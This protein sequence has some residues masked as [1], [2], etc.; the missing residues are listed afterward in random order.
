MTFQHSSYLP[1]LDGWRCVAVIAVICN[2]VLLR[3]GHKLDPLGLGT[4]GVDLF[5]AISGLLITYRMLEEHGRTGE[6]GLRSFYI[7]RAFRILP[8]ALLFLVVVGVLSVAG[9][10]PVS[11]MEIVSSL[12]FFRNYYADATPLTWYTVHYWSLSVEEH[13]YL[14]WPAL[15]IWLGIARTRKWTPWLALAIAA[16]R[17]LDSHF[18]FISSPKLLYLLC[19]T[20]YRLDALLWGC[21][22]ALLLNEPEWRDRLRRIPPWVPFVALPIC[23]WLCVYRP[24][25][26]MVV[27]AL[28]FP[29]VVVATLLHPA[30]VLSSTL[31]VAPLRF[32][33]KISYGIYLWQQLFFIRTQPNVFGPFQRFP[34]NVISVIVLA[35][36]SYQL[37][38]QPLRRYGARLAAKPRTEL[39]PAVATLAASEATLV[40]HNAAAALDVQ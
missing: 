14:L 7:R 27:I 16:W 22:A 18:H 33:G 32:V 35:W 17:T 21:F 8:A 4:L 1:T 9:I 3:S 37:F 10:V 15:L 31:E 11:R 34:L 19:R 23:G 36:L 30:S 40:A 24:P 25:Q 38:E 29:M 13:F 28:L 26:C 12:F 2:H 39:A 5:F 6:I 20:D